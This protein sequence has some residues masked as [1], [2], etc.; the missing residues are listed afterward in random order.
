MDFLINGPESLC[1]TGPEEML[2]LGMTVGRHVFDGAV[3]GLSGPMG[4]GKTTLVRGVAEG[5]GITEGHSVSSPTF[6]ILQSY[7]CRELTLY[8]LDLYRISGREDLDSTGYRDVF[9]GSGVIVIEWVEREPDSMT[10]ENLIIEMAYEEIGRKVVFSP[11][12]DAYRSLAS[13]VIDEY[14]ILH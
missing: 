5:M 8:H 10:P 12:G 1:I 9:G 7:P 3:I 13:S 2:V 14:L 11:E 6:T 4:V